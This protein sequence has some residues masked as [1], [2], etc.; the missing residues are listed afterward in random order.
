MMRYYVRVRLS[1]IGIGD[2]L[3]RFALNLQIISICN[4]EHCKICLCIYFKTTKE[5]LP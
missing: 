5:I 1:K 3:F 4:H 2:L